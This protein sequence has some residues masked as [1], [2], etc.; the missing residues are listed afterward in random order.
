MRFSPL[1]QTILILVCCLALASTAA[2][3]RYTPPNDKDGKGQDGPDRVLILDG[4]SVHNVGSLQMHRSLQ[5]HLFNWGEWGSRPGTGEPYS[6]APSAQWPAGSGVE[7]LFTAGLWV[8]AIKN[9]IPSVSTATYERE[10]RPSS[11]PRDKVYRSEE[12]A[13]NG[14]RLPSPYSDDD[15]DGLMDEDYLDGRDNDGDGLVDE[16]FGAISRLMLTCRYTDDQEVSRQI[17]PEHNPL[18]ILVRQ[19]SYQW[20]SS[21]FKNFIGIEYHITNIGDDVLQDIYVGMFLDPDAGPRGFTNYW[22][23]DLV[24]RTRV[25]WTCTDFGFVT[26]DIAYAFDADGDDGQTPGMFGITVLDRPIDPDTYGPTGFQHFAGLLPFVLG[27]EPSND[28]ERYEVLTLGSEENPESPRDYRMLISIGPYTMLPPDS[29]MVFRMAFVAGGSEEELFESAA[30]A[31]IAFK[32]QW[33]DGDHNLMTG[34]E[35]RETPRVGPLRV[36]WEDSCRKKKKSI[37]DSDGCDYERLDDRFSRGI[38]H[39]AEGDTIWSNAD[40]GAECARKQIC[41]YS[42]RDS[43]KFRTG[44]GG[45]ETWVPWVV[46]A[47]PPAPRI[48]VDDHNSE[49]VVVYWDNGSEIVPDAIRLTFDFE[50]YQV[51]RADGWTRKL[52][53]SLATGPQRELWSALLQVDV[54]NNFG[55]DIGLNRFR[56]EPLTSLLTLRQIGDFV[57]YMKEYL[58]EFKADPPCPQGVTQD[59][60]DTLMALAKWDLGLDGGRQ[61]Y[62]YV[63]RSMLLGVPYFYAVVAF[64][65]SFEKGVMVDGTAGDAGAN[66]VYVE[67]QSAAQKPYAYR[68]SEIYVVPNPVTKESMSAWSLGPTNNRRGSSSSS[69]TCPCRGARFASTRWPAISSRRCRSTRRAVWA[70]SSGTSLAVTGRRSQ[71]ASISTRSSS[72]TAVSTA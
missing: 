30:M 45:R 16:D 70:R 53:T 59:V 19:E 63:D 13:P 36:V 3:A 43:L 2:L 38:R 15:E 26:I 56:Y 34:I 37:D 9:G 51:W 32:G 60:C 49:G 39:V 20:D 44:V 5:M 1:V 65:H 48:R 33:F 42:E 68:E 8:G 55:E 69:E 21:R 31:E 67:P 22:E 64:D 10:F 61:Y 72:R 54:I 62:R 6:F 25:G 28:F 29:T 52:G 14:N 71:A 12:G 7:Y 47:A 66:F 40:C 27:G 58:I 11:D 35:G 41:G 18:N 17:Y 57:H 46:E 4:T 24:K 50:G 23:D